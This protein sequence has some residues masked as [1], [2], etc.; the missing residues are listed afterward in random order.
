MPMNRTAATA[1]ARREVTRPYRTTG[2]RHD[3]TWGLSV[4]HPGSISARVQTNIGSYADAL[5]ARGN[6]IAERI[7]ALTEAGA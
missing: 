2:N 3:C 6:W 1:Q 7:E 4:P 5:E